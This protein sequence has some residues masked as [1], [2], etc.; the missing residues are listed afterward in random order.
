MNSEAPRRF[1]RVFCDAIL[2]PNCDVFGAGVGASTRETAKW[3]TRAI[4]LTL[5]GALTL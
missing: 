2:E 4:S 3:V 1:A 5:L